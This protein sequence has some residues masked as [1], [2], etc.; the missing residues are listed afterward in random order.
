M[1][2]EDLI[3]FL[4]LHPNTEILE[5]RC[6]DSQPMQI[7][8]WSI[9]RGVNRGDY[10]EIVSEPNPLYPFYGG[11][12]TNEETMSEQDKLKAKDYI[13]FSGN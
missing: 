12:K 11:H 5:K 1:K 6:S 4:E 2:T 7:E 13:F 9:I 3:K 10:V 8:D